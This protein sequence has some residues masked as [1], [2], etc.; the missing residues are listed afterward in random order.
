MLGDDEH[1]VSCNAAKVSRAITMPNILENNPVNAHSEEV[2][3]NA[4]SF[5][6]VGIIVNK[7]INDL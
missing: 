2:T 1:T 7:K 4:M 6:V 5:D 3:L